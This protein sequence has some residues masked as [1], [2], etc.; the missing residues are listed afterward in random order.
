[1]P[2]GDA[3]SVYPEQDGTALESLRLVVFHEALQ[4]MKAMKLCE[5][6][7]GKDAVVKVIDET[8]G[9]ETNFETC[10]KSAQTILSMR[11]KINE[12][13]KNATK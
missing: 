11:E 1:M 6:F 10:A 5:S 7:Y 2:A 4:D 9:L 3:Y 13:I 8:M 12:M